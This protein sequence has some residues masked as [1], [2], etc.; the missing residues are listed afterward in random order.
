MPSSCSLLYG[1]EIQVE[2]VCSLDPLGADARLAGLPE[3]NSSGDVRAL[4][5]LLRG[6]LPARETLSGFDADGC[7][8]AMR[9][10]GM[11]LGSLKRF[12]RE[13]LEAVPEATP[14]L[15]EL[16]ERT[17]MVPRDVVHHY[18]V[19]NPTGPRERMY[20]GD[21][22]ER[23]LQESVRMV[24]PRLRAALELCQILREHE[25]HDPK[26]SILLD[27]LDHEISSM[28]D[29]IDLVIEHVSPR[30]FARVLRPYFAE[31]TVDGG[32]LLG[33]AAAQVPLWLVDEIL[34]AS[35]RG[36]ED[37]SGFMRDSVRYS[38]PGWR[39]LHGSWKDSPS[40]VTRLLEAYGAAP[41]AERTAPALRTSAK[42]LAAVLR[43]VV[44]FRGRHL[45]IAKQAYREELRL[46]PVGSGGA[47]V[48][49]LQEIIDLTRKNAQLAKAARHRAKQAETAQA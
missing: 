28:V 36:S 39:N 25:P 2:R 14:L 10:R 49:L 42:S 24:F 12:G 16:G 6:L 29:S 22:Q 40:L 5:A 30:F 9:D 11:V 23:Y 27:A 48:R 38:L 4:A 13:P 3:I 20:T 34:W 15:L 7:L 17:D 45:G 35:D 37:Y 31:I 44:V 43:T 19:W 18:C 21:V 26:F 46:Y 32:V 41:D 47:S 8:A 33:P 1:N